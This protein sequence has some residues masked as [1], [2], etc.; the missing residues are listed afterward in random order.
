MCNILFFLEILAEAIATDCAKCSEKHKVGVKK[1]FKKVYQ[2]DD[3]KIFDLLEAKYDKDM[4][5]RK[6]HSEEDLK[7]LR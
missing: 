7:N 6:T 3:K 1:F 2:G 4:H 5:F